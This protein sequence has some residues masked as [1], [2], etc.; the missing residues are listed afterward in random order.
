[1]M[2]IRN[3]ALLLFKLLSAWKKKTL[4]LLIEI[5]FGHDVQE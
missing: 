5:L 4:L 1:M 3:V 2:L